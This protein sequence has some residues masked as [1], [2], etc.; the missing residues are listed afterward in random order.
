MAIAYRR[1]HCMKYEVLTVDPY[2]R[3]IFYG[4]QNAF[5]DRNIKTLDRQ[6]IIWNTVQSTLKPY[7]NLKS[8]SGD[9]L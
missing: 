5:L 6:I 3:K 2:I 9:A 7:C 8:K 1:Q 4:M